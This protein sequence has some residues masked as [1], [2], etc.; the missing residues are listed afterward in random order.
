MAKTMKTTILAR[1]QAYL[2]R[3]RALGYR[4]RIE[5]RLLLNFARFA[6]RSGHAGPPG[7]E[8]MLRWAVL[9][10][11][12]DQLYK[13]RRLEVV[14]VFA[15]HQAALEPLTEVPPRHILGPAHRRKPTHLYTARQINLLLARARR[16][17]GQ[18]R[19]ATYH[20]LIGLL[21]CT[22][23]RI[24]EAL[25]LQS[26]DADLERGILTIR[27][28][29]YRLTRFV[30]LHPSA[31]MPL[32]RYA[33][34]R[35]RL[36]PLSLHF[37]VSE[38]GR[39]LAYSTVRTAFRRLSHGLVPTSGR[40]YVRLHDLRHTF[41]CQVLLRWERSKKRAAGRLAVLSRYLGHARVTDTYWYLTTTPELLHEAARDFKHLS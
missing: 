5:G 36:H 28:S 24:S 33:R 12:A 22:G 29:K 38:Q 17:P 1:V 37:F 16:L 8:V 18:L 15:R 11:H 40:R 19:P 32:R 30:P 34:K 27:E 10:A 14:R 41:A 3:R 39:P 35:H 23:L 20:A 6:D 9:P 4:L 21:S 31:L 26:A 13:A 2:A 25:A 7:K